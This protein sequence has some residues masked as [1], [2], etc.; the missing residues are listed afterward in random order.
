VVTGISVAG[1][2][3]CTDAVEDIAVRELGCE[4]LD[5]DAPPIPDVDPER[6]A[7]GQFETILPVEKAHFKKTNEYRE[8]R[9]RA[10]L[11][12]DEFLSAL[13]RA[14]THNMFAYEF[15]GHIDHKGRNPSDRANQYGYSY[16]VTETIS[17]LPIRW[18]RGEYGEVTPATVV[19]AS[20]NSLDS[21]ESH[22]KIMVRPDLRSIGVGAYVGEYEGFTRIFFTSVYSKC[23][24]TLAN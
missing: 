14:H 21:S 9:Q 13:A 23:S 6:A 19:K 4:E 18:V 2:S 15:Q 1:V 16:R 17:Y 20:I 3:G 12:Y 24:P 22:R 5:Q 8:E 11:M 10:L 7:G